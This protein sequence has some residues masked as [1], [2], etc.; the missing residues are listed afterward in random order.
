MMYVRLFISNPTM[1]LQSGSI[2]ISSRDVGN[3]WAGWEIA[4]P[5]FGTIE[6]ATGQRRHAILLIAHPVFGS[7]LR[8]WMINLQR[9]GN[10]VIMTQQVFYDIH[11]VSTMAG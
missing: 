1:E 7:Q 3:R 2:S 6:G 10:D 9:D 4:H 8:P 11:K 5:V